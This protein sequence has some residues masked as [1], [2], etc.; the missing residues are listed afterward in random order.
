MGRT[1]FRQSHFQP[2]NSRFDAKNKTHVALAKAAAEAEKVAAAVD[3]PEGV[4]FQRARGLIRSALV[5]ASVA[6]KIDDL[7][8]KLLDG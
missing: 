3:L 5:E 8:A 1:R 6:K 7:V 2:S 4:K